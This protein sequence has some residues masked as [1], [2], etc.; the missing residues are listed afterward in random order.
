[1]GVMSKTGQLGFCIKKNCNTKSHQGKKFG[2]AEDNESFVF[3]VR[4][5]GSNVFVEPC[6]KESLVPEMMLKE[7]RATSTTLPN[8]VK[9]FRAVTITEDAEVSAATV[10]FK[11]TKFLDDAESFRTPFKKRKGGSGDQDKGVEREPMK[12]V[13]FSLHER[14]LPPVSNADELDAIVASGSLGKGGLTRIVSEVESSVIT[15]GE[16]MEEVTTLTHRRFAE[17]EKDSK[18][19]LG[20]LQNLFA[21]LGPAVEIDANFE[22][23]TLWGTTAQKTWFD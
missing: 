4:V 23:P 18:S 3:I 19:M 10:G 16:A 7:W 2:L 15:L 20:V 14:G 13:K 8:W 5:P 1:M 12:F 21:S 22:A 9:A 11:E 6:V 17:N